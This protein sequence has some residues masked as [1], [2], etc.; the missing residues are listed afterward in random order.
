MSASASV[1][2]VGKTITVA[3]PI[4][5]AFRVYT[6]QPID[7]VPPGHAF[8]GDAR[9]MVMQPWAGG[10][11]Y[12]CGAD[13]AEITR[14]TIVEWSPPRRLVVTW[15]VGPGWRPLADDEQAC[16]IVV[17]FL[18]AGADVTE[19]ALTYTQLERAGDFAGQLRAAV[20]GDGG[21]GET[22]QRYADLVAR[23]AAAGQ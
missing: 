9:A 7:W 21:P 10:R 5:T 8:T 16:R 4:D 12:E 15:R 23:Q 14:G 6:E 17:E 11:F 20:V 22:L 18:P 1:P 3:A 2:D 19:L 13:G